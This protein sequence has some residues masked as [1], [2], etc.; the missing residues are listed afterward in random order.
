MVDESN[1][2][3]KRANWMNLGADNFPTIIIIFCIIGCVFF[4]AFLCFYYLV[5]IL[6]NILQ[7]EQWILVQPA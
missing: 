1:G 5:I 4:F 3:F 2:R 6:H 7:E